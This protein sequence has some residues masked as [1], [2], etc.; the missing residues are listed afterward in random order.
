[1]SH[2][3]TH[4]LTDFEDGTW[5][6]VGQDVQ[7][8]PRVDG[9]KQAWLF[10]GSCF[11][12][13]ALI[14]G[15]HSLRIAT[16][17][18]AYIFAGFPFSYGVFQLYYSTHEPFASQKSGIAAIGT[19][20]TGVMYFSSPFVALLLQRWPQMARPAMCVAAVVM[21]VSLIAASFCNDVSGLIATQ[22]VMYALGGLTLY[23]PSINYIDEWFHARKGM[24]GP[25]SPNQEN[26]IN[27]KDRRMV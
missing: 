14:W 7:S 22:G 23:F 27:S 10:L 13:E 19:T 1:M 26:I 6:E 17:S 21:I 25:V 5:T 16:I 11:M 12:L 20:Q 2:P 9:G 8:L 15:T 18:N 24:V 4:E 3:D